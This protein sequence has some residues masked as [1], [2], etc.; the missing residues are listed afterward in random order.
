MMQ[1]SLRRLSASQPP[2][3]PC[4]CG[5]VSRN[6][7]DLPAGAFVHQRH[8]MQLPY[9]ETFPKSRR[10]FAKAPFHS[11][12]INHK[13]NPALAHSRQT[14]K[15]RS[16]KAAPSLFTFC[17]LSAVPPRSFGFLLILSILPNLSPCSSG[18]WRPPPEWRRR[19]ARASRG[20]AYCEAC[21]PRRRPDEPLP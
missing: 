12:Y 4:G 5:G 7:G 17:R 15:R 10:S 1:T 6:S 11:L 21:R 16:P 20:R 19:P 9:F 2:S 14:Q 13:S 18:R 8:M 3:V